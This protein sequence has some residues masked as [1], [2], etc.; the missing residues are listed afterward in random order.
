MWA[1][2]RSFDEERNEAMPGKLI[3]LPV[4]LI[5]QSKVTPLALV[6]I[7]LT[8]FHFKRNYY[9]NRKMIDNVV[10]T[11]PSGSKIIWRIT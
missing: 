2:V 9:F 10:K 4:T 8:G 6:K 1:R 5:R 3:Y 11:V 7:L